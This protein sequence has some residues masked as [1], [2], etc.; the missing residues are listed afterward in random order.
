MSAKPVELAKPAVDVG[1]MTNAL[2]PNA[3]LL[4]HLGAHPDG[5]RHRL[6]ESYVV[7][8][9]VGAHPRTGALDAKGFRYL[10][11]QVRD[12]EAAH[13]HMCSLGFDEGRSP[14]RLGDT[15]Y[16]SFIRDADGNWIELSQRASLTGP[17]PDVPP[18]RHRS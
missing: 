17:L 6:G 9:A 10:T 18:E 7:V 13:D 5:D 1:L 16:I 11:V 12:V 2:A 8:D 15:A 3:D 14:I 4:A